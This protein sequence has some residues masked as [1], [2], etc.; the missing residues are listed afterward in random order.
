M[1]IQTAI[2]RVSLERMLEIGEAVCGISDIVEIGTSLIKDYGMQISVGTM[3]KRF[4]QMCILADIK[5]CDEGEYE[6]R[7]AYESGADIAVVMGFSSTSTIK[8]CAA[9]AG[10]YGKEYLIDLLELPDERVRAL[11]DRFPEAIF[12]IHLPSDLQGEGLTELVLKKM[13]LLGGVH[14]VAAAGGVKPENLSF[15]KNAGVDIAIAGGAITGAG[16]IKAAAETFARTAAR[17]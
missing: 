10:E 8:A 13:K 16:D 12:G 6:F 15:L 3:R 17:V 14:A 1:K 9:V 2:D 7:K 11:A 4:P 5:T